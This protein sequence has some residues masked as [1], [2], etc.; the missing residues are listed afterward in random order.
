MN[1]YVEI[2]GFKNQLIV[3][4]NQHQEIG[5]GMIGE[6]EEAMDKEAFLD[7]LGR[8][9][10]ADGIRYADFDKKE[11]KKVAVC[12]GSGS[13]LIKDAINQ[14]ADAFVTGDITYHKFFDG[15]NKIMLVDIGH[16]ESE[17]YTTELIFD[18]L[19]EKFSN[20]A[21]YKSEINTN[22]VKYHR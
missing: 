9:F 3:L 7:L 14:R 20:F 18:Y 2:K 11:I 13:F 4:K 12:G 16:Y 22:P 19:C 21:V 17:Q 6:F 5:S 1:K 10:K 15:D 8:T